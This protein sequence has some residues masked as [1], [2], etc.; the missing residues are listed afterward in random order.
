MFVLGGVATP[1]MPALYAKAEMD[2][3]VSC[4][5][6]IFTNVLL[7]AGNPDV[8]EVCTVSLHGLLDDAY[9]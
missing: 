6:A 5:H 1:H 4:F 7:G 8:V 3:G 2:P 9:A